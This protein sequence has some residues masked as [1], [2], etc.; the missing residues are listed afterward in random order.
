[1]KI[2]IITNSHN[3]HDSRLFYKIGLSLSKSNQVSLLSP[4]SP[5]H[6]SLNPIINIVQIEAKGK[7]SILKN[8]FTEVRKMQPDLVICVEPL[9]LLVG[10]LLKFISPIS[11]V[12]DCHEFF[13]DAFCEKF[14]IG[15]GLMYKL[16]WS[17]EC[18]LIKKCDW[19]LAVNNLH[20]DHLLQANPKTIICSNYPAGEVE[21]L[22]PLD[23]EFDFIY[24]G[25]MSKDRG[26]FKILKAVEVLKR[27]FPALKVLFVGSFKTNEDQSKYTE[28]IAKQQLEKHILHQTWVE[29]EKVKE[30][31]QKSR[32]GICFL[33]PGITRYQKAIPLKLIEYLQQGLPVIGNDFPILQELLRKSFVGKFIN[34]T[35]KDLMQTMQDLL[36]MDLNAY[37]KMSATAK[38]IVRN[39]LNWEK[40][41]KKLHEILH[42][43]QKMLLTAYFFPPLGGPAVQRP[44]KL[45]TYLTDLGWEIDVITVKDI[46]Y[47]S[48]DQKL[49]SET[50][51]NKIYPTRSIDPMSLIKQL[52]PDKKAQ[53]KLYFNTSGKVKDFIKS[54]FLIDDKTG[55]M[56]FTI[57]KGL[58]LC[59]KNNYDYLMVTGGPFSSVISIY[60]LNLL[61]GT[62]FI[63]DYRDHWTLNT[64][65]KLTGLRAWINKYFEHKILKNAHI[66]STVSEQ[67]RQELISAFGKE[68]EPKSLVLYN[69]WD[70][71]DFSSKACQGDDIKYIR[72]LGNFYT[73]RTAEYFCQAVRELSSEGTIPAWIKFQFVGNYY[74]EVQQILNAP[75]LK[76]YLEVIP[77]VE[78]QKAIELLLQSAALLLFIPTTNGKGVLTGKLL[79][80]IRAQRPILAMIPFD[81]EAA[82]ILKQN[83][84]DL[85]CP[86]ED[87]GSIKQTL[88]ALFTLLEQQNNNNYTF[89][90]SYSREN[91][92]KKL[93]NYIH[94]RKYEKN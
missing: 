58:H 29:Y 73:D 70:E 19:V 2:A 46:L 60:I 41:E 78:H 56:P 80:Y 52:L 35:T 20:R 30:Y 27:K 54:F 43:P 33:N 66:V 16:Y 40:E 72:Y 13:A 93:N 92:A 64:D 1:M 84:H 57:I 91:Q 59:Y 45:A 22:P 39:E 63:V 67:M 32:F 42:N 14:T 3:P 87:V 88:K 36:E 61:T 18:S 24:V 10:V 9:T 5:S 65:F 50:H 7:I 48:M 53:E 49:L 82:I 75:D 4:L 62:P 83:G 37:Q 89:D 44:A 71:K 31:L 74:I 11:L 15:R 25:G 26:I 28:Y 69:G 47:H 90:S 6:Q 8:L 23:K 76:E 12:Y 55:W 81:S 34:Y 79:E 85:I 17:L 86:M 38:D 51:C 94:L 21:T 77:Q 68:I